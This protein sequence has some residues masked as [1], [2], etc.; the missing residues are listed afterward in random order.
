MLEL[1]QYPSLGAALRAA[2]DRWPNEVCLIESDRDKEKLRLTYS[3]F[4]E[5]AMP[6]A[7]AEPRRLA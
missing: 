5:L 3:D 2:I 7:R 1:D 4:K 6:L